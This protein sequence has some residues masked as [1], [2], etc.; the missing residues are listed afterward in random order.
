MLADR[1]RGRAD[2]GVGGERGRG[3]HRPSDTRRIGR[4]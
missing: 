2:A 3:C 4:K 1:V